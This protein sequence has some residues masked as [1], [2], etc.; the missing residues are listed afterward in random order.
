[1]LNAGKPDLVIAF[2]S[3]QSTSVLVKEAKEKGV[4]TLQVQI[5]EF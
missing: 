1:M 5:P 3:G 2:G 4:Q